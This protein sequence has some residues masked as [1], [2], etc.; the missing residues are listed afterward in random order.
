MALRVLAALLASLVLSLHAHAAEPVRIGLMAP[1][2][3]SWASEGLEMRRTVELLAAGVNAKG[4]LL[5]RKVEVVVEDDGGDPRTAALA[6]Q[7][8]ASRGVAAKADSSSEASRVVAMPLA[9][10]PAL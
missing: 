1:L 4:G 6:A 5:G 3:G 2:T 10:S 8:L 9:T 7:R